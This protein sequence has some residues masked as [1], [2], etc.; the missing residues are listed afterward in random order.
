MAESDVST[1]DIGT[2]LHSLEENLSKF[3]SELLDHPCV[4][5][6][7]GK[8]IH[9]VDTDTITFL[10]S[11]LELSAVEVDE[12]QPI[13]PEKPAS[14]RLELLKKWKEEGKSHITYK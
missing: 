1:T 13:W 12:I 4:E 10:A 11:D 7:L 2:E 5:S 6:H 14:E 3:P 9:D 8:I